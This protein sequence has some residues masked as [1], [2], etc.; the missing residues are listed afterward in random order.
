MDAALGVADGLVAVDE[1]T[2][3]SISGRSAGAFDRASLDG[4]HVPRRCAGGGP[5]TRFPQSPYGPG[6]L[7][8]PESAL[9]KHPVVEERVCWLKLLPEEAIAVVAAV[10]DVVRLKRCFQVWCAR[11]CANGLRVHLCR[12]ATCLFAQAV[13]LPTPQMRTLMMCA[14]AQTLNS[15]YT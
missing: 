10:Y 7:T 8:G 15:F 9:Q 4:G 6:R 3:S 11:K 14:F 13:G 5:L 1:P 12:P 2:K